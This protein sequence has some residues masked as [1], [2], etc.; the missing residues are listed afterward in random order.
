MRVI[1]I[2]DETSI[3]ASRVRHCRQPDLTEGPVR[4]SGPYGFPS[5]RAV[6][7]LTAHQGMFGPVNN[8]GMR[9]LCGLKPKKTKSCVTTTRFAASP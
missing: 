2:V 6:L 8:A 3:A 7:A 5:R 1:K 9:Y 4:N